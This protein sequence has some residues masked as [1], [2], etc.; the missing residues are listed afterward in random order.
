MAA[1][2]AMDPICRTQVVA[3]V[4]DEIAMTGGSLTVAASGTIKLG[5]KVVGTIHEAGDGLKIRPQTTHTQTNAGG[6]G[7]VGGATNKGK[8]TVQ[9]GAKPDQNEL[10]AGEGLSNSG[11]DVEH[12][13]TAS[14][15]GITGQR[16]SDLFVNGKPV[17]V[18]T[19]AIGTNTNKIATNIEKKAKQGNV[20]VQGDFSVTQMD[21]IAA[22]TF[23][24]GKQDTIY[25]QNSTGVIF[26][27]NKN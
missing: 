14:D 24:K 20:L 4:G 17:D 12:R 22:R 26:E 19:P 10:R 15:L 7:D 25:F 8:I 23:G 5:N 16:T 6:K 18:Y 21:E 9:D 2:C 11:H 13:A 3:A 27:F 1:R